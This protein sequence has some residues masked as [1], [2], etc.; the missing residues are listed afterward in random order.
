MHTHDCT[1]AE[2]KFTVKLVES[3]KSWRDAHYFE[4]TAVC[5]NVLATS[6]AYFQNMPVPLYGSIMAANPLPR[7]PYFIQ[8]V[9]RLLQ[10]VIAS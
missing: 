1:A 7:F 8:L 5:V 2:T 10:I 9:F 3:T 6:L 4:M